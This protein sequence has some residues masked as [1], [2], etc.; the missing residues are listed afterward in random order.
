MTFSQY[1]ADNIKEDEEPNDQ[2]PKFPFNELPCVQSEIA[3]EIEQSELV[4]VANELGDHN[5][6]ECEPMEIDEQAKEET[7][8]PKA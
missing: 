2:S 7:G 8:S 6:P 3:Y 5:V 1:V 4:E